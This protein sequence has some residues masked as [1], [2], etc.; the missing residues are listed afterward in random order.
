MESDVGAEASTDEALDDNDLAVNF[1]TEKLRSD[2]LDWDFFQKANSN[3]NLTD[4]EHML[5]YRF[6]TGFVKKW[7]GV[8]VDYE[9]HLTSLSPVYFE[10]HLPAHIVA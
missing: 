8:S 5:V 10:I 3:C 9:V 4:H 1:L 7:Y 6:A 2:H